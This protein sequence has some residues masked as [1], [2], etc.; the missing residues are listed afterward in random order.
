VLVAVS[1]A[2]VAVV[3]AAGF[4]GGLFTYETPA[5]EGAPPEDVRAAVP[6]A[7]PSAA[8]VPPATESPSAS[9]TSASPSPS[10]ASPSPSA[11]PSVSASSASPS[12]SA[13]A[14][15]SRSATSAAAADGPGA[16]SPEEAEDDDRSAPVLRRGDQGPEVTELQERLHQ[17]F[18]YNDE[19]DGDFTDRVENA[20]RNYQW[21]RNVGTDNLGV[22]DQKTRASLEAQT[23]EP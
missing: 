8:S 9:P 22:Y 13:S 6:D 18:L 16:G 19:I 2:V 10:S 15:P 1:G 7:S 3:V 20:L 14:E 4:A 12:P 21:S 17:L 23:S 5:R 11:S